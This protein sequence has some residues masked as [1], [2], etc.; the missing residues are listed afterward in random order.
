MYDARTNLAADVAA[1]VR[2]H[3]PNQVF[4]SYI[5]RNV[6]LSEAPSHGSTIFEL[7]PRSSGVLTCKVISSFAIIPGNSLVM[8]NI[9]I[10]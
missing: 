2:K 3:F 4:D 6:R 9:S 7:D 5:P 8:F 10:I 1:E